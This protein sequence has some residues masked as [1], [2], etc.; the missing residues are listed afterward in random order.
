MRCRLSSLIVI[1]F[2]LLS[3]NAARAGNGPQNV[4]VV[5]NAASAE[6][7]E[8]GNAYRRARAIPYRQVLTIKTATT[9]AIPYQ[10]YLDDIQTPIQAYL[11]SQQL[12]EEVT[13]IVLT[14]GIPQQVLVEMVVRRRVCWRR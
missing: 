8:I 12:E 1:L 14:R 4:L 2:A 11:K 6:S 7:L 13:A 10:S 9:Y 5:V 3:L